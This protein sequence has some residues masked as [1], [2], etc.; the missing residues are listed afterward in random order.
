[1]VFFSRAS[2]GVFARRAETREEREHA[3]WLLTVWGQGD[4]HTRGSESAVGT[5]V[6]RL[7]VWPSLR[8]STALIGGWHK[9]GS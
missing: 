3:S 7:F 2:E 8:V 1:M 5:C 4:P 6:Y 9:V